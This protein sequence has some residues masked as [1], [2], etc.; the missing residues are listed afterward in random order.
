MG[1]THEATILVPVRPAVASVQTAG[2]V[3]MNP[4]ETKKLEAEGS[5]ARFVVSLTDMPYPGLVHALEWLAEYPHGCLEQTTSRIFPLLTGG[6]VLNAYP[7]KASTNRAEYVK[8][9]VRRVES[10][11]RANDFV[12][13]PDCSYAPW[14]SEVSL[15]ASHFLIEAERSGQKL[16]PQA[17]ESVLGFLK[18]WAMS[19]DTNVSVYACH[20]L[21]LAGKPEKDRMFRLYDAREK[22]NA[23]ARARLARAFAAIHDRPRAEA[24]MKY[25]IE[26]QSVKEAAFIVLALVDLD[27]ADERIAGL[28]QYLEGNRDK[29]RFSWGTTEENAHALMAMGAYLSHNA[30]RFGANRPTGVCLTNRQERVMMA[31]EVTVTN[32]GDDDRFLSWRRIEWPEASSVT[33]EANGIFITRRYLKTDGE[34]A[35]MTNLMRGEMLVAELTITSDVSRVVSDLVIEDLFAGAFEPVHRELNPGDYMK[36]N[37]LPQVKDWVMRKDARDDRMLVFSKKF[38][39]EKGHEAKVFYPVRVVSAGDYVLPGPAVEGMYNPRLRARRAPDRI[40][41]RH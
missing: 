29:Q 33:N 36:G 30:R 40:V 37:L 9:G 10:M 8:A 27:P 39:L 11:I 16:T 32:V 23:L 34:T 19:A 1:E 35:D 2:V 25:A 15:Y 7:S 38:N 24:L 20:T 22:L 12:M 4:G 5:C 17:K 13:W 18:R 26:P 21:A 3:P 41:V 14:D 28:I 6:G 31:K